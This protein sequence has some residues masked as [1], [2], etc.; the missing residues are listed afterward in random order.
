MPSLGP[1]LTDTESPSKLTPDV[2]NK[3]LKISEVFLEE[4]FEVRPRDRSGVL[5][6]AL[7]LGSPEADS[8]IEE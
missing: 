7:V 5:L 3:G 8:A 6:A 4:S 1:L 2:I